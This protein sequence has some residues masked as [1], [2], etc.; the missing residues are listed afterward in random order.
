ML[1]KSATEALGLRIMSKPYLQR[2]GDTYFF[3]IA[4]PANLRPS[5]G[6][7]EL[8]RTLRTPDRR[9]AIPRALHLASKALRLFAEL[10][11]VPD[12]PQVGGR[13]DF[14]F[15]I[16]LDEL[17]FP[18]RIRVQG[19]PHEQEAINSAIKTALESTPKRSQDQEHSSSSRETSQRSSAAPISA[20]M[21][22]LS[23]VIADFLLG[24]A[25]RDIAPMMKKYNFVMP[26]FLSVVSDKN[27]GDLR[28][29]DL[30]DFFRVV[31]RLPPRWKHIQDK[32]GLSARAISEMPH[33]KLIAEDTFVG[34]YRACISAFIGW[35]VTNRQ[36]QGFPTTLTV[37]KVAYNGT[38]KAGENK[39][40]AFTSDELKR[41]FEGEEMR[42]VAADPMQ[43]G[44]FWL[45][46]I[47]LFTGARVNEVCQINPQVDIGQDQAGISYFHIAEDTDGHEDIDKSVKT[48]IARKVPIHRKLLKLGILDYLER[49]KATGSTLI[50]P[51]WKP[52]GGRASP[53]AERWF[54][55]F[56]R[57]IGLHGVTNERGKA[58]R[59][60]HAF[61]HTLLSYGRKQGLNLFCISGHVEKIEVTNDVGEGYIDEDIAVPLAEKRQRLDALEYDVEFFRPARREA[62]K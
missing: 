57:D 52:R 22:L 14:G 58:I 13:F 29:A 11:A 35:G 60:F 51:Q 55:R 56:L 34:T 59:G 54:N 10:R 25:E 23:Q 46:H 39:Q 3:R 9:V 32:K 31:H 28:Q 6:V 48:S 7:K 1:Q 36:D 20:P 50:F 53:N 41:L 8:T 43:E 2:R 62:H 42:A 21:P 61:R 33:D 16:D 17:G 26:M 37:E 47:G 18:K 12:K 19:E 44:R 5:F 15:E 24:E 45:S 30:M 4:V 49:L 38:R 27:V 40:R